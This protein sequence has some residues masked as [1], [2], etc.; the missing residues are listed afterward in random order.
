LTRDPDAVPCSVNVILAAE[1]IP[2]NNIHAAASLA[3]RISPPLPGPPPMLH[4]TLQIEGARRQGP[5]K[6]GQESRP[7][8]YW[9]LAPYFNAALVAKS[10]TVDGKI[11]NSTVPS[12][13]P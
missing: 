7:F 10:S 1:Q 6:N 4:C 13:D 11:P 2:D 5:A 3:I 9:P 12:A 8:V